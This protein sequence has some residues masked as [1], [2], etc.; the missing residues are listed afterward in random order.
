VV[1]TAPGYPIGT[2]AAELSRSR[3]IL[4]IVP[5]I[6]VESVAE[7]LL[8]R[9]SDLATVVLFPLERVSASQAAAESDSTVLRPVGRA[10]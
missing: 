2:P 3:R 8:E 4:E 6:V 7:Q 10:S 5:T 1:T 9:D